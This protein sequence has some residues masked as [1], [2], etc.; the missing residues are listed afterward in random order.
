MA[1][2][3]RSTRE[4][5]QDLLE[6]LNPGDKIEVAAASQATGLDEPTC[7]TILEA[8]ARVD[9]FTRTTDQIFVRR[10]MFGALDRLQI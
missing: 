6:R 2:R 3:T 9:L 1:A 8:L 7:E 4:R 10:R 5:L